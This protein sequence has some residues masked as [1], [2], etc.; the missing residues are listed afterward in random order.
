MRKNDELESGR[1]KLA[2]QA[3]PRLNPGTYKIEVTQELSGSEKLSGSKIKAAQFCFSCEADPITI[4]QDDIYSVYPPKDSYGQFEEVLPH[5]VLKRRTLPWERKIGEIKGAPWL[6][7][8]LFGE[9][10][11]A[12]LKAVSKK[13]AFEASGT[14]YCPPAAAALY[15]AQDQEDEGCMVL[16]V[17]A[18]LFCQ[19]CPT[20]AELPFTAHAR[21]VSRDDKVTEGSV[22]DDW[23]SVVTSGRRPCSCSGE[24]GLK[25]T[26][27]LV[28]LETYGALLTDREL[29]QSLKEQGSEKTVTLPVLTSWSFYSSTK[30][31]NFK[32]LFENLDAGVLACTSSAQSLPLVTNLLQRGYVPLNHAL[33]DGG[34]TVSWYRGPLRPRETTLPREPYR[35]VSDAGMIYEPE[36]GMFDV[37][38]AAAFNLGRLLAL[39]DKTYALA[40]DR[41]R[42]NNKR[43]AAKRRNRQLLCRALGGGA[44]HQEEKM[45]L[46]EAGTETVN[47]M[48]ELVADLVMKSAD[49]GKNTAS[50][51]RTN[52]NLSHRSFLQAEN[53]PGLNFEFLTAKRKKRGDEAAFP[54]EIT[55]PL[56]LWSLLYEVPVSYLVPDEKMLPSESIRFFCMDHDWLFALLDG[57]LSLGRLYDVD[58]Q[59]DSTLIEALLEEVFKKRSGVRYRLQGKEEAAVR[60][61][62]ANSAKA[63][64][65]ADFVS[66]GF[67]LRSELVSGW[68]GLEFKAC[69]DREKKEET[70]PILRLETLGPELLIGIFAG[71]VQSLE[72]SQP[73][74]GM[75]FG[76]E[77]NPEGGYRKLLRSL[78]DGALYDKEQ[79][80]TEVVMREE[81]KGVIDW[82]RT[83]DNI[84]AR[85][86]PGTPATSA[87]LAL[88]LIHNPATGELYEDK[89][90]L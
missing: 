51:V 64:E 40:L 8:L 6:A 22:V 69:A 3:R 21:C 38:V 59:H 36:I 90:N 73:P 60:L 12:K 67:L 42:Q 57:A 71:K 35:L 47:F 70:L 4:T 53:S 11:E 27:Y 54:E 79:I 82:S 83:A 85:L 81:E 31:F 44:L 86:C 2:G 50:P 37:S 20:A 77:K 26:V 48:E 28:S 13:E 84:A 58:Y 17:A 45:V 34:R 78:T 5:M 18:D 87:H 74:E 61:L 32:G 43:E 39:K 63:L 76:F 7:L 89:A 29:F 80:Y 66:T 88:E 24:T 16:E 33:R 56:S 52:R 23:L 19:V 62:G 10:E 25:N 65:N 72:I 49:H 55:G 1:I 30:D 41:F 14:R 15:A 68:R 75:H 46:D 9:Q